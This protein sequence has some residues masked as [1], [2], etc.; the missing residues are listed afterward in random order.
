MAIQVA[1]FGGIVYV[2]LT[3]P[4]AP[5]VSNGAILIFAAAITF[6]LTVLPIIIYRRSEMIFWKA[7]HWLGREKGQESSSV[8]R[9]EPSFYEKKDTKWPR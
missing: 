1:I 6:I 4:T 2:S 5:N 7:N 8:A 9:I 3:D